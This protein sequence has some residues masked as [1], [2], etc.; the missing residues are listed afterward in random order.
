[1]RAGDTVTVRVPAKLNLQLAVGPPRADGYHDLVTVFHAVSLFDEITARPSERDGV[2]VSGEG[3]DRVPDD[4]DNLALRAVAALRAAAAPGAPGTPADAGG[5]HI[6]IAK[7]I[8]VA[9]GLAGGSADAA[10]ALVAC[11]EL[12]GTGLDQP[13]LLEIA[14][15]VGSD[16]AFAVLGG[17]AVGRGRGERLTPALAPAT[18]YHWVLAFA[19][20]HLSTPAVYAALDRL[21]AA[22]AGGPAA[23]S[24]GSTVKHGA[25]ARQG[26]AAKRG[27]AEPVLDAAL[28]S[29]LRSGDARQLGR[30]L[31]NDL[32]PAALSLFPAL[33]KT[34]AAG[35]E[36][37]ALGALVSGSGPTCLFLAASAD[38]ALDLAASLSGAGVC[39]SVARATGP[40][41]G[42][43]V[44]PAAR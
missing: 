40:V 24:D 42:A 26:S 12:W 9:A 29:A 8:P 11:N 33:R 43:A 16:V 34:L 38:R 18:S 36:L 25:T 10:A 3:A 5:V 13:R 44:V 28:M 7:R 23:E 30:A 6:T 37:G 27:S 41:P 14:A 22:G 20:G 4:G 15:R 35:L 31:S 21:R 39:R 2:S 17:T 1:M 32:Q 19:D